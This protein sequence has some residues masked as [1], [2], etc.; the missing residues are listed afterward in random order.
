MIDK[1]KCVM[2]SETIEYIKSIKPGPHKDGNELVKKGIEI[3]NSFEAGRSRFIRE[4]N[5]KYK[6]HADY[7]WECQRE[8]KIDWNILLGLATLEDQIEGIKEL[9]DFSQRTGLELHDVQCIPSGVVGLPKE[10]K[11]QAPK[12][13]SY[14]M[15]GLEDYVAQAEAAPMDLCFNDHH[16][17]V[18]NAIETTINAL[19]VGSE[20]VGEFSQFNWGY[21]GFNDDMKRYEDMITS[22]GIMASKADEMFTIES[23]LDDGYPGYFMDCCS[24][25]GYALLEHYIAC[26]LCGARYSISFGGLVTDEAMRSAIPVAIHKLLSTDEQ[27]VVTYI[28]GS[29]TMQWGE[30]IDANYGYSAQEMLWSILTEKHYKMGM[31]FNPVSITEKIK[32]PTVK[33]LENIFSVGKRIE[34]KADEWL[35]FIDWTEIDKAVDVMMREGTIFFQNCLK[36]LEESGVDIHDPLEMVLVLAAFDPIKFEQA[37]HSSTAATDKV[38]V[39]PF[40]PTVLGRMTME[41]K[42]EIIADLDSKGYSGEMEGKKIV[43]G[44]GDTHTYGLIL[45]DGVYTAMGAT[46]INGGVDMDPIDLLDLADESNAS[47]IGVSCHNGQALDYGRQLIQLAEERGNKY[48]FL[49]G[50]KLNSILPGNAEPTEVDGMLRE[51]GI[52][53]Y[54]E[55]EEQLKAIRT[56]GF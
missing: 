52:H 4:S 47:I 11:E 19:K 1:R 6:T 39:E 40:Y 37:F 23:Y 30:N 50:G 9:Y 20:R 10:Y 35:P 43:V 16:M 24:Y 8:G 12:T 32:V 3:G 15:D 21:A 27:L 44:S 55:I 28:N 29:T 22:F 41:M 56:S 51:L 46:V 14:V 13:T 2:K 18:P 34:A 53:A 48:C 7:K 54:N 36:F 25:V 42:D 5:G 17:C 49:M 45:I 26:E 38:A 33:E 31:G